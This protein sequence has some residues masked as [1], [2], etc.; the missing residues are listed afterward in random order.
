L[1]SALRKVPADLLTDGY[2][3]NKT[4]FLFGENPGKKKKKK[5]GS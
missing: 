1:A 4:A 5:T 3:D 2:M